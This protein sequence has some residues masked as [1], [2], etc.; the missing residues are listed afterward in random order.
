MSS[1]GLRHEGEMN[2]PDKDS[3]YQ[4]LRKRGIRAIRVTERIT[5][6]VRKGFA[7][8]R[9]R[10]WGLI[11]GGVAFV[12]MIAVLAYHE[13]DKTLPQESAVSSD[14]SYV[15]PQPRRWLNL[16]STVEY[17]KLFKH[18]HEVYLACYAMPGVV[19]NK[20]LEMDDELMRDFKANLG[21]GIVVDK[22]DSAEV[23][24]LKGIVAGMKEDAKRYLSMSNGISRLAIWLEER[25]SMEVGYRESFLVR[26]KKGEMEAGD[27]ND[28]FRAMGMRMIEEE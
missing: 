9:R 10:D 8:L 24:E 28:M 14:L 25:Q 18:R 11:F 5:P 3:V 7:G 12:V 16:P 15:Q 13:I 19:V 23:T 22:G 2:A 17:N 6:I 26:V 20:K 27:V 4:E 21:A 1:D